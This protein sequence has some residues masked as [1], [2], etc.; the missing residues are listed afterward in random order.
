MLVENLRMLL[1]RTVQR[2]TCIDLVAKCLQCVAKSL[3]SSAI[4]HDALTEQFKSLRQRNAG[5]HERRPLPRENAQCFGGHSLAFQ[6]AKGRS[7]P[8]G[9]CSGEG[10]IK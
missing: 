8:P 7:L 3:L 1:K 5:T 2:L 10:R 4:A 6:L 9:D